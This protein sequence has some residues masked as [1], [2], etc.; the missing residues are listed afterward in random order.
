MKGKKNI[1]QFRTGFPRITTNNNTWSHCRPQ[2]PLLFFSYSPIIGLFKT[3]DPAAYEV[4]DPFTITKQ[5]HSAHTELT[6]FN[7]RTSKYRMSRNLRP[8]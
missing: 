1:Y 2:L 6:S 4:C 3:V 5:L 7:D 8:P